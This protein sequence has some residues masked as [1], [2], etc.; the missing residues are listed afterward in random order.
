MNLEGKVA[1]VTGGAQGLGRAICLVLAERGCDVAVCD[2]REDGALETAEAV[3]K[4]GRK[5]LSLK[6][7][8]SKAGDVK[9]MVDAALAEW[10]RIDILVNNAGICKP[11]A[12]E[13]TSE[14]D[15]D[16]TMAINLKGVF[17]CSKAVMGVMKRQRYGR[18]VNMASLAGQTGGILSGAS[19]SVSKAGVI[20]LT[21]SLAGELASYGVTANAI[22]PGVILTDMVQMITGGDYDKYIQKIPV[23]E[24]GKPEDIAYAVAFL[25]SDEARHITGETLS[26]NGGMRMQ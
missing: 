12:I 23:G 16:R 22:A 9:Q 25:A 15:W 3:R 17:L 4:K 6:V 24:M 2:V 20:C 8:V 11:Q 19:Y 7:D 5:A 21:K 13:A 18:I 14:E 10:G 26:V 1:I